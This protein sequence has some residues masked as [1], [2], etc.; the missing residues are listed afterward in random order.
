MSAAPAFR[1]LLCDLLVVALI[2]LQGCAVLPFYTHINEEA[3]SEPPTAVGSYNASLNVPWD[4]DFSRTSEAEAAA[5]R[6]YL[7]TGLSTNGDQGNPCAAIPRDR[8]F[9]ALALSGGG[10]RSAAFSAAI[11]WE[12]HRL[13]VLQHVD[14][15]SAVSGGAQA[16][17]LYALLRDPADVQ[18]AN[19]L[20]NRF[21]LDRQDSS[22]FVDVFNRNL[23][24]DWF[25][26]LFL[27]WHLSAFSVSYF[28]RTDVM[29]DTY[30]DNYYPRGSWTDINWGLRFRDINPKRPNLMINAVDMSLRLDENDV[31]M[32]I[33]GRCFA[34][35]YEGFRYGLASDLHDFPIA[36]A[37]MASSAYPGI[38]HYLSI[39]DFARSRQMGH[40]V[41]V[42]LADGG[43]R[44]H[45]ALVPINAML[46]RFA[47]GR[48]LS[49]F[50]ADEIGRACEFSRGARVRSH[51]AVEASPIAKRGPSAA[52]HR[53]L[54]EKIL[55]IVIDG[56]KPPSGYDEGD[57]D[58]RAEV[59]DYL[60]PV[61]KA[62][63][64][65]DTTLD[66]Q[67]A[68]RV[69]ELLSL[70][71]H[72]TGKRLM[73]LGVRRCMAQSGRSVTE[74]AQ[75]LSEA[76]R[77][78]NTRSGGVF[79]PDCCPIIGLGVHNFTKFADLQFGPINLYD[80]D[81]NHVWGADHVTLECLEDN[82]YGRGQPDSA[83]STIRKMRISL[84]LS[85]GELKTIKAAARAVVD[86]MI[87]DFCDRDT[88]R[89]AG[90][91]GI[92]CTPPVVPREVGCRN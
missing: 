7:S 16:A 5:C 66:D 40:D 28:D 53:K 80:L 75:C 29:A 34:F 60:V 65:I 33:A 4:Y 2:G 67:R 30:A 21:V 85:S 3:G 55:V 19:R 78:L 14:V 27:P 41:Y 50:H 73:E 56:G 26:S 48:S 31:P 77:V 54:P 87:A 86:E 52:H 36:Q 74:L 83:Y 49:G 92:G 44:D 39:K 90:V 22:S 42:H 89:L 62:I 68:L 35:S 57:A 59:A 47:E 45:L 1:H 81:S 13:G 46:R 24:G 91:E 10:S 11:M 23:T 63:D 15:I 76:H 32:G 25:V 43:I 58:P 12:L 37:V 51:G 71:R 20:G 8:N 9:V 69:V 61:T 79:G 6:R 72:L 82:N 18:A 70:R 88:G 64:A 84:F 17:A 38:Y